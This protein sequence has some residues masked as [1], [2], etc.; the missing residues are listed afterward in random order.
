MQVNE[1]TGFTFARALRSVLRHDPD[2]M[3]I[4]EIRDRETADMAIRSALTGHLVFATLHTNDASSA[5]TRLCDI[6]IEPFLVASSLHGVLAQRLLRRLCQRCKTPVAAESLD[7]LGQRLLRDGGY[8]GRVQPWEPKGCEDCRFTGYRGRMAA[9]EVLIV[10]LAIRRLIQQRVP[11]DQIRELGCKEGMHLLRD[12][13]LRAVEAGK[14][15]VSE[16]LRV[17]QGEF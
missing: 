3:L 6:G 2:I 16:V 17:T 1:V 12:S 7:D 4:G 11:A 13:A 5:I 14:T 15:S 9:G 10:S 8:W